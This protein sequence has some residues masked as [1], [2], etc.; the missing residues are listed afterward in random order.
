MGPLVGDKLVRVG[1]LIYWNMAPLL[2]AELLSTVTE[3]APA[4][5]AGEV[6]VTVLSEITVNAVAAVVPKKTSRVLTK[7]APVIVT[8][9][10]P[11]VG[12]EVGVIELITGDGSK[13]KLSELFVPPGVPILIG[14]VPTT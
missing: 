12:P 3:A 2:V 8:I 11:A 5:L 14:T 4:E 1:A 9:V 13:P 10:P 6:A 7:P